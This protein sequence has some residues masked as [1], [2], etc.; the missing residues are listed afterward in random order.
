[1]RAFCRKIYQSFDKNPAAKMRHSS[2]IAVWP[3]RHMKKA[4]NSLHL[5]RPLSASTA[6]A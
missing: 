5:S 2:K 4:A 1:M 3:A 6:T